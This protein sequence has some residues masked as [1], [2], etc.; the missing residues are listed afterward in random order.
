[1]FNAQ[2]LQ[3]RRDPDQAGTVLASSRT[4]GPERSIFCEYVG[5]AP[6]RDVAQELRSHHAPALRLVQREIRTDL[7]VERRR[8]RREEPATGLG[9]AKRAMDIVGGA[10]ALLLA[11]PLIAVIAIVLLLQRGPVMFAQTRTGQGGREFRCFKFRTMHV[12]AQAKLDAVLAADPKARA[13]W[14]RHHKLP[15]DP[16][17]TTMGRFLRRTSLD[18]LPQLLNV[19]KGDMSLVGPRPVPA[20]ELARY[21]GYAGY[22]LSVKPGL[23]GLWQVNGRN[24]TTYNRRIALDVT[25]AR[26]NSLALDLAIL[27]RTPGVLLRAT[28]AY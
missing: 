19:L 2:R 27:A 21:R 3:E 13:H 14:R 8:W 9:M 22:Y 11:A 7:I 17:V 25:Y 10:A 20:A 24:S 26:K 18:E 1:M 28:G 5:P 16:R 12:G 23:T 15:V 4:A 6:A